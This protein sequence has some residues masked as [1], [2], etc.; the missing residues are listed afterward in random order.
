MTTSSMAA[1]T[2]QVSC[3]LPP[4]ILGSVTFG[5]CSNTPAENELLVQTQQN[6]KARLEG[7]DG[8]A[9]DFCKLGRITLA[10]V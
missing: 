1:C 2:A 4:A 10:Y 3:S 8:L 6:D 7:M 5:R 9:I